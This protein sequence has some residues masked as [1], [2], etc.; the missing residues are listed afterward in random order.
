MEQDASVQSR[1]LSVD[2][3]RG[4]SIIGMIMA[5]TAFMFVLVCKCSCF[6]VLLHKEWHGVTFADLVFP[7]FAFAVGISVVLSYSRKPSGPGQSQ[8]LLSRAIWRTVKLFLLG[9]VVNVLINNSFGTNSIQV[10][11]VL[12]RISLVYLACVLFYLFSRWRTQM[13]AGA[14][15]LLAYWLAMALIPVPGIGTGILEPGRNLAAWIDRLIIPG[16][17]SEGTWD[18]EG[19]FS[20][21]PAAVTG[22]TGMLAGYLLISKLTLEKKVIGLFLGGFLSIVLGQVWNL[23]FP[24][25]KGLWTSSFVLY[26]SGWASVTLASFIWLLEITAFQKWSRICVLLGRKSLLCYILHLVLLGAVASPLF[27]DQSLMS[28]SI[29][30]L[31]RVLPTELV[32]L[33]FSFAIVGVCYAVV[34]LLNRKG[35]FLRI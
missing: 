20:T 9:F 6:S 8:R 19:L 17:L 4:F 34:V 29:S 25:N 24:I 32:S 27:G 7:F 10:M 3:F 13:A 33:L 5:D 1:L 22:M 16:A 11:G 30:S 28:L 26:T 31:G 23:S 21:I 14:F 15:M 2:A 18:T 35:I 12:Q